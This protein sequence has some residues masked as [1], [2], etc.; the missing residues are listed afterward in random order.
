MT[1][2]Y[3]KLFKILES[4]NIKKIDLQKN[5]GLSSTTIAKLSKN[6]VLSL[7]VLGKNMSIFKL[8]SWRY[9]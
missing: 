7:E 1:I 3:E 4:R 8:S 6:E 9:S 2:S 5:I